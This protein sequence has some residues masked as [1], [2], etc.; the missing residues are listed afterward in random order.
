[1][2]KILSNGPNPTIVDLLDKKIQSYAEGE[3]PHASDAFT[4]LFDLLSDGDIKQGVNVGAPAPPVSGE[5][6]LL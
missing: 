5:L 1:L 3:L 2:A 4:A 6:A